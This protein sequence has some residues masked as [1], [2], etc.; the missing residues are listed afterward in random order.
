MITF[1]MIKDKLN[2]AELNKSDDFIIKI[3]DYSKA[4][5]DKLE[6]NFKRGDWHC[7]E[8]IIPREYNKRDYES[9]Y[10]ILTIYINDNTYAQKYLNVDNIDFLL[11]SLFEDTKKFLNKPRK[12][13]TL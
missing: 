5:E 10:P 8:F 3:D 13:I 4:N 1:Q 12:T 9:G 11:K 6:I 2:I 7:W